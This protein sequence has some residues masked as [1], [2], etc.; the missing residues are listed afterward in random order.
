MAALELF[1]TECPM[2]LE[3]HSNNTGVTICL[4][5]NSVYIYTD[6][7]SLRHMLE[8]RTTTKNQQ[9]YL[10]K[11]LGYE[12]EITYKVGSS[13]KLGD[14]LSRREEDLG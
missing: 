8:Q 6:Q 14:A 11:L 5:E 2:M 9:N 13:N 1:P 3:K 12:F 4:A 10:A 7:K